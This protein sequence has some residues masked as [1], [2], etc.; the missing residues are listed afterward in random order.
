MKLLIVDDSA[1]VRRAVT[2]VYEDTVFTEIQTASDGMLAVTIFKKL[3]P[4]VVTLDI[5]MPH[6]DGLAALRQILKIKSDTQ[7]LVISALAVHYTAVEALKRGA[8]QFICKPFTDDELKEALDDLLEE[9]EENEDS[10]GGFTF[11]DDEEQEDAGFSFGSNEG[12]LSFEDDDEEEDEGF[13]PFAEP[14]EEQYPS[15]FVPTP[16]VSVSIDDEDEE[17]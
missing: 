16:S 12:G 8:N 5:T 10:E 4:D 13:D 2:S 11:D 17:R 7:V 9:I 14:S 1:M 3:L 6:M 15:G